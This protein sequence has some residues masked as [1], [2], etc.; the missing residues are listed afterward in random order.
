MEWLMGLVGTKV[1]L[2]ALGGVT[3]LVGLFGAK[4]V[5]GAVNKYAND[6]LV[7]AMNPKTTDPIR[8]E[9]VRA[10]VAA[11]VDLAEY[12]IPDRGRGDTRKKLVMETLGRFLPEKQAA[13]L[14]DLIEEA[15]VTMDDNLKKHKKKS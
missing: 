14:S 2:A 10:L 6:L 5:H 15:V 7:Q 9:K 13:V 11:A 3:A 4:A 1:G 12:A 8:A